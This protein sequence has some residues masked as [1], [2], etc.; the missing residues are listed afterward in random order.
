MGGQGSPAD[1]RV[2]RAYIGRSIPDDDTLVRHVEQGLSAG[3]AGLQVRQLVALANFA[4]RQTVL[5]HDQIGGR[6]HHEREAAHEDDEHDDI[7][8]NDLRE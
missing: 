4:G 2:D 3:M 1:G 8:G 5:F 7:E 6:K